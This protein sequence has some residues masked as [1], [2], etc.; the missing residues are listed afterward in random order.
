MATRIKRSPVQEK[1]LAKLREQ[2]PSLRV[3]KM[4][5]GGWMIFRYVQAWQRGW[6]K[7]VRSDEKAYTYAMSVEGKVYGY[8]S[9]KGAPKQIAALLTFP[10][11]HKPRT[12]AVST[13]KPTTRR[14]TPNTTPA[15]PRRGRT[16][17]VVSLDEAEAA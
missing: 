4:L 10:E 17:E 15:T 14:A 12:R 13:S 2:D 5:D 6:T 8:C 16:A 3:L 7:G 11:K 9:S 1:R